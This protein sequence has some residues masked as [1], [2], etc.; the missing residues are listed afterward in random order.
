MYC[1]NYFTSIAAVRDRSAGTK[2]EKL[3]NRIFTSLEAFGKLLFCLINFVSSRNMRKHVLLKSIFLLWRL[4]H[5][6]FN[7]AK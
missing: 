4:H 5:I 7:F 3:G 6:Y 1:S 2:I